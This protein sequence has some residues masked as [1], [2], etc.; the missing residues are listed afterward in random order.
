M[1]GGGAEVLAGLDDAAFEFG[2]GEVMAD[3]ACG[4]GEYLIGGAIGDLGGEMAHADGVVDALFAG[5]GVGVAGVDDDAAEFAGVDMGGAD[6]DG[7]GDDLVG[8]ESGGG[9]GE[10][11]GDEEAD[12]GGLFGLDAGVDA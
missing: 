7:G 8:G 1:F 12:V 6:G 2:H 10:G 9:V 4:G 5:A 3:D 11:V